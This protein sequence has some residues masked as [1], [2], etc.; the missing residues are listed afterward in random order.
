MKELLLP[1]ALILMLSACGDDTKIVY[2]DCND[3]TKCVITQTSSLTSIQ[4]LDYV[5]SC[6][7]DNGSECTVT[8]NINVNALGEYPLTFTAENCNTN[9][10]IVKIIAEP[11]ATLCTITQ[12]SALTSILGLSYVSSCYAN[13]GSTC[14]VSDNVDVNALGEY[15]L[16]FTA[17][18]CNDS[19]GL[20][21]I[22]EQS[23]TNPGEPPVFTSNN[24]VSVPENQTSAI[25]L[26]ASDNNPSSLRYSIINN[27]Y[28][29]F[30][31][32]PITGVV[33]F[34]IA[35]N[36]EAK[37]IYNF[38]AV[39]IDDENN[40]ETQ[41]TAIQITDEFEQGISHNGFQ[42]Q[43][44]TSPYTGK[45]WL[46]RNVGAQRACL[47]K[48]DELCYG[49]YYQWGR[50][51][52]GHEFMK[53][54]IETTDIQATS[55][56]NVGH[57]VFI[58]QDKDASW[59]WARSVDGQGSSRAAQWGRTNGTSVCPPGYRVPNKTELHNET[60]A[61]KGNDVNDS[62]ENNADAFNNFLKLPSAGYRTNLTGELNLAGQFGYMWTSS[63]S[64]T[65][66]YL[67]S[68]YFAGT[69]NGISRRAE[70]ASIRCLKSQ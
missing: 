31:V 11:N 28:E 70:G 45:T 27:D 14:T 48:D 35:P 12:T 34:K 61:I 17:E 54:P 57:D 60:I 64:S 7:A 29:S 56:S 33:T 24:I 32:D 22:I 26:Q 1:L 47:S 3:T 43:E 38:T 67:I 9:T 6:S 16:A 20:V 37:N 49:G 41:E 2:K 15:P 46:D 5:S 55:V 23:T 44:V 21:R 50:K 59:D 52:D 13:N 42:Y 53:D 30:N 68:Y 51:S 66:G 62:I 19:T 18:N 40:Y 39:V 58:V 25:T 4:G 69:T 36:Y 65:Y 8:D 10:G 63:R